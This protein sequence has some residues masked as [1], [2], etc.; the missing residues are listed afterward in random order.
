MRVSIGSDHAAILLRRAIAEHLEASGHL[1]DEIGPDEATQRVD[2]PDQAATVAR[3]VAAGTADR[4]VLVCGTG[5]GMS[6]AAN[7]IHGVRAALVHDTTTASLAAQHNQANVLC[8][9]GRLLA[10]PFALTMVDAWLS[11]PFETRHQAR[12]DKVHGLETQGLE[13]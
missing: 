12:L 8:L 10:I 4:G 11:T 13:R 6:I 9:G 2:Y 3:S 7:K 1:V 5:I